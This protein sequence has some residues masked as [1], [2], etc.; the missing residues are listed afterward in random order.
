LN[1]Q[2]T[3]VVPSDGITLCGEYCVQV[4]NRK[5]RD[6]NIGRI[7]KIGLSLPSSWKLRGYTDKKN[8]S[9]EGKVEAHVLVQ[10][11]DAKPVPQK[12]GVVFALITLLVIVTTTVL[13]HVFTV[14]AYP[15]VAKLA[16]PCLEIFNLFGAIPEKNLPILICA[17]EF[18]FFLG[19]NIFTVVVLALTSGYNNAVPRY[20][21]SNLKG[22]GSRLNG[23]H[24]NQHEAL[25][26]FFAAVIFAL[27]NKVNIQIITYLAIYHLVVRLVYY[28]LYIVNLHPLRTL[29]FQASWN[30]ILLL[31]AYAIV[32]AQA[33]VYVSVLSAEFVKILAFQ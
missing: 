5:L 18:L 17:I 8:K 31:F 32:P 25:A 16:L 11:T 10:Q 4:I 15:Q 27:M 14:V 7:G 19:S 20:Q 33:E 30:A 21:K 22:L 3:N 13:G 29:V 24:L 12:G 1:R 28:V 23:A 26:P 2:N 6:F 9:H